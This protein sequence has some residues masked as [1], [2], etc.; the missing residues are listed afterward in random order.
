MECLD[1]PIMGTESGTNVTS[2]L[3]MI[4][5]LDNAVVGTVRE[6]IMYHS[7]LDALKQ[8]REL[9]TSTKT[10]LK[11]SSLSFYCFVGGTI[12]EILMHN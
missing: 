8:T 1:L 4:S 7:K 9:D 3:P 10:A 11:F 2:C 5:S 6:I 12:R